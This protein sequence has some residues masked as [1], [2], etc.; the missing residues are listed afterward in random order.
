[1]GHLKVDS[2]LRTTFLIL[3]LWFMDACG[4]TAAPCTGL[5]GFYIGHANTLQ[6]KS[7]VTLN[8]LCDGGRYRAQFFT[9][10]GDHNGDAIT[11]GPARVTAKFDTGVAL[12]TADLIQKDN[13]LTGTFNLGD[14]PGTLEATRVGDSKAA[15]A[16]KPRLDSTPAQW[17]QDVRT[18]AERL[19]KMHA[20][21]FF[22]LKKS[23]FDAEIAALYRLAAT[24]N[25]DEMF[26]GLKQ[27]TKSIG[28]GHTGMGDPSDRRVMPIEIERFGDDFRVTAVGPGLDRALGAR[29]VKIGSM[30]IARVWSRVLTLT[31]RAESQG[32]RDA[33][34][35]VFLARGYALHGLDII[36]DRNHAV[37]TLKDN[38]GHLSDLDIR[39]LAPGQ[40][41]KMKSI[42]RADALR[43]QRPDDGFWCNILPVSQ[44]VYCNWRSYEDLRAKAAKMFTLIGKSY[45]R[46]LILDMRDNGGGDN[47]VGFSEIIKPIKARADL[48]ARGHLYVLIGP[49]TFSAAM[50]NAV[51]FQ[52]ET[53]AILVGQT[54]GERPNSYQEPRQFHLPNS[55]LV[56]RASTRWYAFRKKG[57]N[58]VAPDKEIVPSWRDVV[59]GRDA[60][61]DW[62]LNRPAR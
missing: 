60:V 45:P 15:D 1:L 59:N 26:V 6:G 27:I 58:K 10:D 31:S 47:T 55:H 39:G 56:V 30:P 52:D 21:A 35:P 11:N 28:D 5:T 4:A 61:L 48:N 49:L 14:D 38:A 25:G 23:E 9:S 17:R 42:Y 51:Q 33:D 18:L 54:I 29:V 34:A 43:Y 20:N 7:E 22:S 19:P 3:A 32:F 62:V 16:M 50:N 12:G 40:D 41:V 24:A 13:V 46:K 53:N 36:P 37:Y 2:L 8:L 57:P 44:A